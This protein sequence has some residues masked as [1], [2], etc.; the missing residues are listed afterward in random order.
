ARRG[1]G[2]TG[3]CVGGRTG[4]QR[5]GRAGGCVSGGVRGRAG[6]RVSGST[7]RSGGGRGGGGQGRDACWAWGASGS[8]RAGRGDGTPGHY[9]GDGRLCR[10]RRLRGRHAHRGGF[11]VRRVVSSWGNGERQRGEWQGKQRGPESAGTSDGDLRGPRLRARG[12]LT[13]SGAVRLLR[14]RGAVV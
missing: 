7:G 6:G 2:R 8:R 4:R 12:H 11:G 3:G 1:C 9:R 5:S 14:P 10:R 13:R